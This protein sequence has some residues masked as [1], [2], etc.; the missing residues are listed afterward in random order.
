[1]AEKRGLLDSA[2]S[3]GGACRPF[4]FPFRIWEDISMITLCQFQRRHPTRIRTFR[5]L[6]RRMTRLVVKVAC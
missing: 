4:S 2:A 3:T 5:L 1:M 6:L